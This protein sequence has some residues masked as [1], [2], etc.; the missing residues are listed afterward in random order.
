MKKALGILIIAALCALSGC[1]GPAQ[2]SGSLDVAAST[3]MLGSLLSEIGGGRI[4]VT[5]IA[6]A[7][8][9]PGHFDLK[10]SDMRAVSEAAF[11]LY[12]GWEAWIGN[13]SLPDGGTEKIKI[14]TEGSLMVPANHIKA[15]RETAAVLSERDSAFSAFYEEAA[16]RYIERVRALEKTILKQASGWAGTALASSVHQ[17]ELLEWMGFSVP[18]VYGRAEDISPGEWRS[19]IELSKKTGVAAVV[20][21]LQSG[22][23]DGMIISGELAVPHAALSNFPLDG[24]YLQTLEDNFLSVRK[25]LGQR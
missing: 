9:C 5:V 16:D 7:G 10:P 12:H 21:N 8:M 2:E 22:P 15:A 18:A 23:R 11:L 20:D 3:A 4:N 13:L 1:A 24:C 17:R 25:A 14:H 19:L 6:P